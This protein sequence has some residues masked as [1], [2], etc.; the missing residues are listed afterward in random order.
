[1]AFFFHLKLILCSMF[2]TENQ[3]ASV[4]LYSFYSSFQDVFD[5]FTVESGFL[6]ILQGKQKFVR[7]IGG[8]ITEKYYPREM[9]IG[10]RS[11]A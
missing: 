10:S 1:M 11:P 8:K 4:H 6:D 9:K 3:L 7:E 5:L 2:Y